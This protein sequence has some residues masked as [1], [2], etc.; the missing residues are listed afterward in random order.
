MA[1]CIDQFREELRGEVYAPQRFFT[2]LDSPDTPGISYEDVCFHLGFPAHKV[3]RTLRKRTDKESV[4][5]LLD[6]FV[7]SFKE[8][9]ADEALAQF[10]DIAQT[11]Y[12]TDPVV[13]AA[14][15]SALKFFADE[16]R[17]IGPAEAENPV[18][19]WRTVFANNRVHWETLSSD[20]LATLLGP[21]GEKPS[22]TFTISDGPG[23]QLFT[24]GEN[25]IIVRDGN[26]PGPGITATFQFG[27]AL[28]QQ[29]GTANPPWRLFARVNRIPFQLINPVPTSSGPHPLVVRLPREGKQGIRFSA[30]PESSSDRAV[31]KV[32]TLWECC[33]DYPLVLATSHAKTRAGKRK[34]SKDEQG[35]TCY[36]IEQDFTLPAQGR[37]AL[38]G[39]IFGVLGELRVLIPG[40]PAPRT[41]TGLAPMPNSACQRFTLNVDVVE[42]TEIAF[43]WTDGGNVP[44]RALVTFDFKG[45]AGP[46]EDS[47][48]GI[49]VRA[50]GGV[51]AK[52]L[53][54]QLATIKKG[55]QVSPSELAVKETGK[56]IARWEI[57]QQNAVYGW[58]PILAAGGVEVGEQKLQQNP[59]AYL[60]VSTSLKL[61]EQANAWRSV[62][63]SATPITAPPPEVTAYVD[64]RSKVLEALGQQFHL[65]EGESIEEINIAR[66]AVIGLLEKQILTNYVT[67]YTALLIA[68]RGTA[69]PPAWRW[70]AWSVDSV[71]IFAADST[72]PAAHLLGPLHPVT[73]TRLFFVQ[74]CLG[75]RLLDEEPSALAQV[76]AHVQPLALGHVIDAQLQPTA[77]IAFPTGE[78]H[79]LWLFHQQEPSKLPSP[80]LANWLRTCGLDP[81]TGP[82]GVDAEILP[83]TLKQYVLAYPS[84]QTIRL[85][86]EDC[87]QRTFEVLRDELLPEEDPSEDR[88]FMKVPGGVSV[89]DPVTRVKRTTD[90][91]LLSYDGDLP[92]RWHHTNPPASL[93]IDLATLSR[94]NRVDFQSKDWG[95][96]YSRSV[97]TARR[98]IVDFSPSGL[99]V[100]SFLDD[101]G[102]VSDL[103]SSVVALIRAFEPSNQQLSWGTSLSTTASQRQTGLCAVPG[104]LTH[105]FSLNMC[106]QI[107][108]RPFGHSGSLA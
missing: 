24:V 23:V 37:V 84:H 63:E 12:A 48:S 49:M 81:Q 34:R 72:G 83:Q 6:N 95:G 17:R 28:L 80:E 77:S 27:Q 85:T 101:P 66:K 50:H 46:R 15:E 9:G 18:R 3:G 38:H 29:A 4:L 33:E 57:Q 19:A 104:K 75:E 13:R 8:D 69:F 26:A 14:V 71:L 67:A 62:V 97:P 100:A 88:L 54:D 52:V 86:L 73:L 7:D 35:N 79:W 76:F 61:N 5:V 107:R 21:E 11:R 58:W 98:G 94:S 39:F 20:V 78:L 56:P 65:A 10:S 59:H 60:C 108:A 25:E 82:L 41:L 53:K 89:Y 32:S 2:A 55:G 70:I 44:H 102:A 91:E 99:E 90:G 42:G 36:E 106:A 43:F 64:A 103:E 16:F 40:E 45:E 1:N 87:S 47:M 74:Q 93:T 51:S 68:A 31:S 22:F 92:L 96:A 30:G 105:V